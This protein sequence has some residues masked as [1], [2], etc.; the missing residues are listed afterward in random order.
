[1]SV[2]A[3]KETYENVE[4]F[5][6]PALFTNE[7][8]SRFTVPHGWFCYDLRGSDNDPGN[9]ISIELGVGVNHCG[10]ILSPTEVTMTKGKNY[11]MLKGG[12][13]FL[14]DERT[15]EEFCTERGLEYPADIR[16]YMLRPASRSEAGLFYA[17]TPELDELL[18]GIGHLRM[19][20]GRRGT[21]FWSR[22]FDHCKGKLI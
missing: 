22:W 2:D 6:K 15:L 7:R 13:N 11:R 9:P 12:L 18:G 8:V 5:G 4:L 17:L 14:G 10:T 21:E 3:R 16:K 1:M 19:D 20:F